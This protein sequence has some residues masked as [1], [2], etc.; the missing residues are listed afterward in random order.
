[1]QSETLPAVVLFVVAA[2]ACGAGPAGVGTAP[3]PA[4][5]GAPANRDPVD[6]MLTTQAQIDDCCVK[7]IWFAGLFLNPPNIRG[8]SPHSLTSGS[9]HF[10]RPFPLSSRISLAA[11]R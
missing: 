3:R 1:V 4:G 9:G 5:A 6:S 8:I 11:I 7:R 2:E 10:E